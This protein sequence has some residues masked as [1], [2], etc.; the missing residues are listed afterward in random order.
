VDIDD[1]E[2]LDDRRAARHGALSMPAESTNIAWTDELRAEVW[3]WR[4]HVNP[5]FEREELAQ[6]KDLKACFK[7]RRQYM[8]YDG[9]L[10]PYFRAG[11]GR[12]DAALKP[13]MERALATRDDTKLPTGPLDQDTEIAF[14]ALEIQ[15]IFSA[16][17]FWIAKQGLEFAFRTLVR[18][19]QYWT[20]GDEHGYG[21]HGV[22]VMHDDTRAGTH[23]EYA[24]S[25]WQ[26]LRAVLAQADDATYAKMRKLAS[27]LRA[28]AHVAVQSLIAIAF[29][30]ER[31]W[32]DE[33]AAAVLAQGK[34]ASG[35]SK[36]LVTVASIERATALARN[37]EWGFMEDEILTLL[38]REG[39]A[40]VPVIVAALESAGNNAERKRYGKLL[41]LVETVEAASALAP[42]IANKAINPIATKYYK[43]H[44]G[45]ARQALEP[46]SK[47]KGIEARG[48]AVVL[49]SLR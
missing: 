2:R 48:A 24:E 10:R 26:L 3:S 47:G 33:A 32:A 4:G 9:H 44:A 31:A 17:P 5:E 13:M 49:A 19:H 1:H 43:R 39:S 42:W 29:A 37:E 14:V 38:A 21:N 23:P 30:T 6:I 45:I 20:S 41:A 15:P 11:L 25:A 7:Q 40:A 8:G 35:W 16:M 46:I 34:A 28:P 36:S 22:W 27:E 12:A 18:C